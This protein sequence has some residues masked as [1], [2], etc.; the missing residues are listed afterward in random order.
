MT[1]LTRLTHSLS[2]DP[3]NLQSLLEEEI[4]SKTQI[5]TAN[6]SLPAIVNELPKSQELGHKPVQLGFQKKPIVK[7]GDM[8]FQ[9]VDLTSEVGQ[10]MT[11]D[12]RYVPLGDLITINN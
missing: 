2:P 4:K 11:I 7:M 1:E 12:W 9:G 8:A 5:A 3:I 10:V 6:P